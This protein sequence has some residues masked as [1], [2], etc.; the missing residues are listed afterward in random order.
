VLAEFD[1]RF[2]G[3]R[4]QADVAGAFDH[5]TEDKVLPGLLSA[6]L[7]SWIVESG[8]DTEDYRAVATAT[9]RP[10]V[11]ATLHRVL[12][13]DYEIEKR[14]AFRGIAGTN[15]I[16][17]MSRIRSA[18]T[19]AAPIAGEHARRLVLL[20]AKAWPSGPRTKQVVE[21]FLR[22][23]GEVRSVSDEDLRTFAAL[24]I[25]L[26][27]QD[28]R[29][30][31]WLTDRRPA[32][33]TTLLRDVLGGE[34]P[35][36]APDGGPPPGPASSDDDPEAV[37]K[38][39]PQPQR[40]SSSPADPSPEV[41]LGTEDGAR[42]PVSR[43]PRGAAQAH[44]HLRRLRIREDRAHQAADRRVRDQGRLIDRARSEQRSGAP[45]RAVA[46]Q[47]DGLGAAR[48]RAGRRVLRRGRRGDLDAGRQKRAPAGAAEPARHLRRG[49][50]QRRAARTGR[51]GDQHPGSAGEA[52]RGERQGGDRR[53]R[54]PPGPAPPR[55]GRAV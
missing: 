12:D 36:P 16:A 38:P 13:A 37:E 42:D 10:A 40:G 22:K 19:V 5:K 6:G 18:N 55:P 21:E 20:R 44:D 31:S 47:A 3:L 25:L 46:E 4:A 50:G 24:G 49:G 7:R 8:V 35:E 33:N 43:R 53:G 52:Q 27:E 17:A 45:R 11:H 28:E 48:R 32:M 15:A 9:V 34:A 29:L 2:A 51:R 1:E 14:W 54:A 23:G 41:I 39:K 30:A 26:N